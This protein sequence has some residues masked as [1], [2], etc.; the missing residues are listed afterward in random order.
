MNGTNVGFDVLQIWLLILSNYGTL[1]KLVNSGGP[2]L[3]SW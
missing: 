1:N 3:L 2:G